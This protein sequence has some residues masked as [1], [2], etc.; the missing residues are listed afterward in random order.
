MQLSLNKI[1]WN[2]IKVFVP[3][4]VTLTL[5]LWIFISIESFFGYFL[6]SWIPQYY[7][8]GLGI[9]V[10]FTLIFIMGALVNAWV[11]KYVYQGID[12]IAKRIP[13]I[14]TLYNAVQQLIDFFDQDKKAEGQ[15][16]VMIETPIGKM[17]GFITRETTQDLA[18][19]VSAADEVLVYLPL[20]YQVGGMM[21]AVSKE[22]L[23]LLDWPV[24]SAMSFVLT[25]GMSKASFVK[26][27]GA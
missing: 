5:V 25:A 3:M 23:T 11:I 2:G 10:G 7:F 26:S 17:I 12:H 27:S 1:F 20:S 22:N 18:L 16:A 9:L 19:G 13:L 6:Q 8:K 4:A 14:K 15:R 24:D 21:I